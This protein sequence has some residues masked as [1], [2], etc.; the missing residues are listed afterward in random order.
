MSK[1]IS[2]VVKRCSKDGS[3][4]YVEYSVRAPHHKYGKVVTRSKTYCAG[5]S[6]GSC[7]VGDRVFIV[8]VPPMSRTK[9]WAFVGVV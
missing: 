7:S 4:I 2:G 9:K 6:S 1:R 5:S 3:T 8:S